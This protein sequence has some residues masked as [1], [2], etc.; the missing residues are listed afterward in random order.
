LAVQPLPWFLQ[1][2]GRLL[3]VLT[4]IL[5]LVTG[6]FAF[7]V[8]MQIHYALR[9]QAARHNAITAR[10]IA[11]LVAAHFESLTRYV[12]SYAR[13]PGLVAAALRQDPAAARI[14][15]AEL[16]KGNS[17]VDR[18]FITDRRG[19]LWAD[20]PP[21]PALQGKNLADRDWFKGVSGGRSSYISGVY[22][23][24]VPPR[25]YLVAVAAPL[26]DAGGVTLGYLVE[27]HTVQALA[28]WLAEIEAP[29]EGR[30]A[31]LDS[32]GRLVASRESAGKQPLSLAQHPLVRKALA[33]QSGAE[34]FA[35]PVTGRDS[36][37]SYSPIDPIGW[38]VL[39]RN[40]IETVA[41]PTA[42]L[43]HSFLVFALV[44]LLAL[45]V[46]AFFWLNT[47][48]RYNGALS[49]REA[50]FRGL[51]E[52]A[53]DAILTV[54]RGGCM[55]L[56]NSQAERWFGYRREELLGKPVEMLVPETLRAG[57]ELQGRRRDGSVFPIEVSLS[58]LEAKDGPLTIAIIRDVSE[59]KKQEE[60]LRQYTTQLEVANREL[61]SFSYSVSHD[62][63]TPLRAIDGFSHVLLDDCGA[64]L[65]PDCKDYLHRVRAATQHMAMLIDDLLKLATVTRAEL[66][67]E[68]V[69]LSH[70]AGEVIAGLRNADPGREV[71]V[72]ITP[73]LRVKG[74]ERLLR[75][76]LENLLSNAWKFTGTRRAARIEFG[77]VEHTPRP[78]Y[79]VRDNGVGFNM[80][81]ADKLFAPFQRLHDQSEFAG[82][83]IGLATVQRILRKHGGQIWAESTPGGGAS[84]Y[85]TL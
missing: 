57:I 4:L 67:I 71:E 42:A 63:R 81:Y 34:R 70:I 69:D 3:G 64:N 47:I 61:E 18:A 44:F 55:V 43:E 14:H 74:D 25:P 53:P 24:A 62:L 29:G 46:L 38:V 7:G 10:L 39:V 73:G 54:D 51:L 60:A 20:Y 79:R 75:I 78:V 76:A 26:R 5:V 40:P 66:V 11:P 33:G 27:Q 23:S 16:V 65:Q 36:L 22:R 12:E 84:F 45:I 72:T 49:E 15:L 59:R 19:T 13:R 37:I 30:V 8:S 2:G 83:G 31:L 28:D 1:T 58:P 50:R 80:A 9:A 17:R 6:A 32:H 82:T 21:A 48:R 68:E 41:A 52:S 56:I 77:L 35:D 85:F